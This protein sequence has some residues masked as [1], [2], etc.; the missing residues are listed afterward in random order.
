M[1]TT[2]QVLWNRLSRG[3]DCVLI[4]WQECY[5]KYPLLCT[6]VSCKNDD[7]LNPLVEVLVRLL[8]RDCHH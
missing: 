1:E 7:N 8:K 3:I 5:T 2:V 6:K 4:R